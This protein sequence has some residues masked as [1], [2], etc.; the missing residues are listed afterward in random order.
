MA[1]VM[2]A[3]VIAMSLA[4]IHWVRKHSG[5]TSPTLFSVADGIAYYHHH[6]TGDCFPSMETVADDTRLSLRTVKRSVQ[7]L[8][9]AGVIAV[10]TGGG[11]G[12]SNRYAFPKYEPCQCGPHNRVVRAR[13]SRNGDSRSRKGGLSGTRTLVNGVDPSGARVR[14]AA[15]RV[16]S[17]EEQAEYEEWY[18]RNLCAPRRE[19]Q[20]TDLE[21][22]RKAGPI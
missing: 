4:M 16:R 5:I 15:P 18:A 3:V 12:I 17:R 10:T 2:H 22:M 8:R 20:Y 9:Q 14:E 1:S 13:Q 11:S 19:T 21:A 6:E 7:A